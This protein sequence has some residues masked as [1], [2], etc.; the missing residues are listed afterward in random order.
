MIVAKKWACFGE[1][2]RLTDQTQLN[3]YLVFYVNQR[4]SAR[5]S[6]SPAELRVP[7]S[8]L[9]GRLQASQVNPLV[10]SSVFEPNFANAH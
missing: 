4:L 8:G 6:S 10:A 9:T 2:L 1:R 7:T 3:A 5:T